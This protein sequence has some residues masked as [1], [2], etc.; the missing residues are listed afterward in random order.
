VFHLCFTCVSLLFHFCFT[1]VSLLFHFCFTCVSLVFHLC[2]T[3]VSLV[4]HL[5]FTCVSSTFQCILQVG[6]SEHPVEISKLVINGINLNSAGF[7]AIYSGGDGY[8]AYVGQL[9][10]QVN[11]T[12]TVNE[13]R[14][15]QDTEGCICG[16]DA[17]V[18]KTICAMPGARCPYQPL[19]SG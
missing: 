7:R 14:C 10:F 19:C 8:S 4:F 1:F 12:L 11:E 17:K 9:M 3:C 16:R 13:Q 2:F 18:E 15:P 6:I 5:C